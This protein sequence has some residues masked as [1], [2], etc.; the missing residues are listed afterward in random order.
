MASL[1]RIPFSA[2]TP[3]EQEL[4]N[5]AL[6]A[7][8]RAQAPYSNFYVGSSVLTDKNEIYAGCNVERCSYTQTTH[9]EQNAIDNMITHAGSAKITMIATAAAPKGQLIELNHPAPQN[10][11]PD[12]ISP[13]HSCGHCR[14][15]I[16]ENCYNDQAVKCVLVASNGVIYCT[17]I[18]ELLPFPFGPTELGIS[19]S[20]E[21][22]L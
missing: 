12:L 7:R 3:R 21:Q 20:T 11:L 15:I 19:Y 10:S 9:A 16:W 6:T 2:F 4:I 22:E 13:A 18:G 1:Q 14:Q 17:T 8:L 5:A